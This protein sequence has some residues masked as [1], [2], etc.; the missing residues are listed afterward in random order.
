M[1]QELKGYSEKTVR[2]NHTSKGIYTENLFGYYPYPKESADSTRFTF[3]FGQVIVETAWIKNI[4][5]NALGFHNDELRICRIGDLVRLLRTHQAHPFQNVFTKSY[6]MMCKHSLD[7]LRGSKTGLHSI[8]APQPHQASSSCLNP[9]TGY[10]VYL[11]RCARLLK[12]VCSTLKDCVQ[13]S[14]VGWG[15]PRLQFRGISSPTHTD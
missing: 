9:S 7:T 4:V 5:L 11:L 10:R 12:K 13:K 15:T 2:C 1:K 6:K 8:T 14:K 3:I